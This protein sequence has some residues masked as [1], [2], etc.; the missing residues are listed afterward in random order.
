MG[1][2]RDPYRNMTQAHGTSQALEVYKMNASAQCLKTPSPILWNSKFFTSRATIVPCVFETSA[3]NA[4]SFL[5]C[6]SAFRA[7]T[8]LLC[9][10]VMR[11][12]IF[13]T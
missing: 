5:S 1:T 8:I 2:S 10:G 7:A 3:M 13:E 12:T 4:R 6:G 11:G 9:A